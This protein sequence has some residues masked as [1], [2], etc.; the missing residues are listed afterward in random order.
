[1]FL[2]VFLLPQVDILVLIIILII[3][4]N[5]HTEQGESG[6]TTIGE[7]FSNGEILIRDLYRQLFPPFFKAEF[8]LRQLFPPIPK[9]A[10]STYPAFSPMAKNCYLGSFF[11]Q[12]QKVLFLL[13][14]LFPPRLSRLLR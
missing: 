14:L 5:Y 4:L 10:I 3:A 13:R 8:L 6:K 11:H 1:M 9:S 2:S 12:F 7:I